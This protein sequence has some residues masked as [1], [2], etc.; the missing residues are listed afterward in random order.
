MGRLKPTQMS[1]D[2]AGF[3]LIE[4]L[5]SAIMLMIVAL[6]VFTAFDAGT[7]ATAQ[8]GYRARANDLAQGDLERIRSLPYACPT[9]SP[10]CTY[11]IVSLITPQSRQ[12]REDGTPYTGP[13]DGTPYT[14]TSRAQFLTET[15]TTSACVT[16]PDS[17]DYLQI[18]STVTWPNMGGRPAVTAASAVSPPSGSVIPNTGS[19]LVTVT[20]SRGAGIPG[21]ALAGSGPAGFNGTTGSSG[22]VLWRNLPAGTYA[23][24]LAGV[25]SGKVDQNGNPPQLQ[26]PGVVAQGTT[27]FNIQYD[28]PGSI[29]AVNPIRFVTTPYLPATAPVASKADSV[30]LFNSGMQQP[31]QVGTPGTPATGISASGLFPF[32]S[33]Y[34]AYA[35]TCQGD[36][37][38]P[39]SSGAGGAALQNI[40]IPPGGTVNGPT[41]QLPALHLTVVNNLS[42]PLASARVRVQDNNCPD[43]PTGS[44]T[45]FWRTIGPTNALGQLPD[46]GLPYRPYIA[47]DAL[48]QGYD[49]CADNGTRHVTANNVDVSNLSTGTDLT[50]LIPNSGSSS[51]GVCP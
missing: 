14:I 42:Q 35:G 1:R 33:P 2:E 19:L 22:C 17:R 10:S 15:P 23:M 25:A 20:D 44:G 43:W 50:L 9:A 47:S 4:V 40:L 16:G 28:T 51:L 3:A 7:R 37:P 24:S 27:T 36:N 39:N 32:A 18:S 13:Q 11:S 21:V 34:A 12:V 26:H 45:Q 5:V 8:E 6:G 38:D 48:N 30:I 41:I 29:S 49:V 46:P 31:K